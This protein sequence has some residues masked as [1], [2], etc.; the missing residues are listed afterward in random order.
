M[1]SLWFVMLVFDQIFVDIVGHGDIHI[2][3]FIIPLEGYAA[4]LVPNQSVSMS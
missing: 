1:G 4:V 3:L 2:T